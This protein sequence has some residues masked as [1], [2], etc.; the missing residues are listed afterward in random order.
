MEAL[1]SPLERKDQSKLTEDPFTGRIV[2][3]VAENKVNGSLIKRLNIAKAMQS[4]LT[5][6]IDGQENARTIEI[7][8]S[9]KR[10]LEFHTGSPI[11]S[12]ADY[13]APLKT[14]HLDHIIDSTL[15][16]AL[17]KANWMY[18]RISFAIGR[19]THTIFMCMA[20]FERF[21]RLI[22]RLVRGFQIRRPVS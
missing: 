20:A 8:V 14:S 6:R 3:R 15:Q 11:K 21:W 7:Y 19:E 17:V 10:R 18:C 16:H 1:P 12:P 4:P 2:A 22:Q 5:R 9:P 13:I